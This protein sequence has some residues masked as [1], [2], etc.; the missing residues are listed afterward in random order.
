M[1]DVHENE[2]VGFPKPSLNDNEWTVDFLESIT[3]EEAQEQLRDPKRWSYIVRN[4][5]GKVCAFGRG[6]T[7]RA[8]ERWA[9][10]HAVRHAEEMW[11]FDEPIFDNPRDNPWPLFCWRFVIWPPSEKQG[12]QALQSRTSR[13]GGGRR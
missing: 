9:I 3:D 10:K 13:H 2:R 6:K 11:L 1:D 12:G 8:C 7:P 5:S 4:P